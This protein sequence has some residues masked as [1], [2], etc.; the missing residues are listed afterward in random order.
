MYDMLKTV[1]WDAEKLYLYTK[2]V[3][4]RDSSMSKASDLS[5]VTVMPFNSS[6]ELNQ[7]PRTML[8]LSGHHPADCHI[9]NMQY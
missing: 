7:S 2:Y 4:P 8:P 3:D 5:R 6:P 9:H 1:T